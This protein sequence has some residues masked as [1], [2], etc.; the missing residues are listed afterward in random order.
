MIFLITGASHT[1]KTWL[2]QRRLEGYHIP[3]LSVDLLKMGLIRSGQTALS[4]EEDAALEAY[5]WPIL[6]EI[7]HTALENRQHLIVEGGYLPFRW[8]E[9]FT[10]QD[11]AHIRF[12]CL[13]MNP[14]YLK[15]HFSHVK[16]YANV[17][18]QR[19]D[20]TWFTLETA[21]AENQQ[22]LD[23]CRK[24]GLPY[25]WI[26]THYPADLDPAHLFGLEDGPLP[27]AGPQ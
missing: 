25:L 9:D 16:A 17:I 1:G 7:L 24:Y 14:N 15:T 13:V 10:L 19:K 18:E 11:L 2:A 21:L 5:L 4:P 26:D 22:Y 20:D 8:R 23:G 3:Y 6:R 27:E 12:C